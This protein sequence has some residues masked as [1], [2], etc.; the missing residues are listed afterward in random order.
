MPKQPD[1]AAIA[2]AT[3]LLL[4]G[5][6]IRD[7]AAKTGLSRGYVG[8][9]KQKLDAETPHRHQLILAEKQRTIS[10]LVES[11]VRESLEAC[12]TIAK[13]AKDEKWVREQNGFNL[14]AIYRELGDKSIRIL[15]AA[16]RAQERQ[17]QIEAEPVDADP[18]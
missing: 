12:A 4:T 5:E 11:A 10:E 18:A 2:K 17:R 15:E 14:S 7:V 8:N 9:L 16:E 3:A 6:T 13:V 1:K